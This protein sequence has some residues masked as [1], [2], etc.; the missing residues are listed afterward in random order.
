MSASKEPARDRRAEWA[1]RVRQWERSGKAAAAFSAD[2]GVNPKTFAYWRWKL[3]QG[4]E[5]STRRRAKPVAPVASF[6]EV[7]AGVA[8]T[9]LVLELTGGRR[10]IVPRG[11]DDGDLRRL[12]TL[13]EGP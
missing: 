10:V 12:L 3:R 9:G 13:L 2:I 7:R 11:F 4:A 6:V 8:N 5:P 1:R